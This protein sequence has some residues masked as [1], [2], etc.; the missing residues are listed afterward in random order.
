MLEATEA[1]FVLEDAGEAR[2]AVVQTRRVVARN[3]PAAHE[4]FVTGG[5]GFDPARFFGR[6]ALSDRRYPHP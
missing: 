3:E 5:K 4:D 2:R 6:A 1:H